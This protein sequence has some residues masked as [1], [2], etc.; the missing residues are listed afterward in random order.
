MKK[1]AGKF[2]RP[3]T[4]SKPSIP[5]SVKPREESPDIILNRLISGSGIKRKRK[6]GYPINIMAFR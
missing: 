3:S 1:L 2:N 5:T 4:P 6:I